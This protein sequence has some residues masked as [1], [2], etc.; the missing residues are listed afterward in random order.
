M[1]KVGEL[2]TLLLWN[3][4]IV[5]EVKDLGGGSRGAGNSLSAERMLSDETLP[6]ALDFNER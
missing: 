6:Y 4:G 1:K 5:L 3:F 2:R